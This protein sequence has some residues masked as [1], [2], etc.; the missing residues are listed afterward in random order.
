MRRR[1]PELRHH[2]CSLR[3][4]CLI[5]N[6][7]LRLHIMFYSSI[8]SSVEELDTSDGAGKRFNGGH[9]SPPSPWDYRPAGW[10]MD[11]LYGLWICFFCSVLHSSKDVWFLVLNVFDFGDG[12]GRINASVAPIV[13]LSCFMSAPRN[14]RVAAY[15]QL[16]VILGR[17]GVGIQ[18]VTGG[19]HQQIE[20]MKQI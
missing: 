19:T 17:L 2:S 8:L 7:F 3:S 1:V 14:G 4:L 13:L 16:D 6:D 9:I 11:F 15:L 12:F 18:Q 10:T 20:T 5:V